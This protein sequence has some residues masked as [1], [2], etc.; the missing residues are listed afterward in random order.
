MTKKKDLDTEVKKHLNA[1][2]N[3]PGGWDCMLDLLQVRGLQRTLRE[4]RVRRG[5]TQAQLAEAMNV[6]QSRIAELENERYPDYKMAT[7]G[8][9]TQALGVELN[10]GLCP[11]VDE[12]ETADV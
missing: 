4:E 10:V 6:T 2:W 1:I 12:A 11:K 8:R 5:L 3:I 7:L 9:W